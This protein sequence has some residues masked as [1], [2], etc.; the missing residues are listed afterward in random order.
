M[1]TKVLNL[2]SSEKDFNNKNK[3]PEK[4]FLCKI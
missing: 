1:L 3:N 2:N 4:Y